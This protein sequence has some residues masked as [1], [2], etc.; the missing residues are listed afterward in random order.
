MQM[1][2]KEGEG[3]GFAKENPQKQLSTAMFLVEE[4]F[5]TPVVYSNPDP[6]CF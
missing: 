4:V 6:R 5:G 3:V 1:W 2:M